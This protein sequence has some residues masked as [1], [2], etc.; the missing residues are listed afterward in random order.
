MCFPQANIIND[1]ESSHHLYLG[2]YQRNRRR[3]FYASLFHVALICPYYLLTYRKQ[4]HAFIK[5]IREDSFF[6]RWTPGEDEKLLA[7]IQEHVHGSWRALPSK[8]G[9]QKCGKSCRLRWI[10]YLRPDIKRGKFTLQEEQTIIQLHALLESNFSDSRNTVMIKN[11][12]HRYL[13]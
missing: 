8:A 9:L 1:E 13:R 6:H 2:F 10:N 5:L 11:F 3:G 7:Y 12:S 4:G